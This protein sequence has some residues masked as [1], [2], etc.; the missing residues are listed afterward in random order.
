MLP[1]PSNTGTFKLRLPP[2]LL[3]EAERA[4]AEQR[5]DLRVDSLRPTMFG[6]IAELF[7]GSRRSR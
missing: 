2:D 7:S 5:D 3:T 4:Y 1:D 6:R